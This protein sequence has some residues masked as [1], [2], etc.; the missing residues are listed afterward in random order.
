MVASGILLYYMRANMI[1]SE[2]MG[3]NKRKWK[4]MGKIGSLQELII[5][6]E[7][8]GGKKR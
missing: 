2:L 5:F 3:A 4:L 8:I 6:S 7:Q 1:E